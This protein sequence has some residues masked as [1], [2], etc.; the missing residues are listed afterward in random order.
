MDSINV[1]LNDFVVT[2]KN[3]DITMELVRLQKLRRCFSDYI[4]DVECENSYL[5]KDMRRL[6]MINATFENNEKH[7]RNKTVSI[8]IL[9]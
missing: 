8:S 4:K 5:K 6:N 1:S 9:K 2:K 7:F 3:Y